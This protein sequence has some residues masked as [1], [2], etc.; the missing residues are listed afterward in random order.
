MADSLPQ[1]ARLTADHALP[2]TLGPFATLRAWRR[3][4]VIGSFVRGVLELI[5]AAGLLLLGLVIVDHVVPGGLPAQIVFAAGCAWGVLAIVALVTVCVRALGR[6]LNPVFVAQ[7]MERVHQMQ[8]NPLV[9]A[10]LVQET[11]EL[12]YAAEGA[13][14]QARDAVE[15]TDPHTHDPSLK[16]AAPDAHSARR[17]CDL[18]ALRR[19]FAQA[20]RPV[21]ATL[22]RRGSR[23]AHRRP[24]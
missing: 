18:D 5:A 8:H 14:I 22:V 11:R 24:H 19:A 16:L 7:H 3:R 20:N 13:V 12:R 17:G 6:K 15:H 10:L 1:P 9:N 23:R 2:A 4:L 21:A